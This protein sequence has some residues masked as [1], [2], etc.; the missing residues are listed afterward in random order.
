MYRKLIQ[1][2]PS[3]NRDSAGTALVSY[4]KRNVWHGRP[5][6]VPVELEIAFVQVLLGNN[7]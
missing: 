5:I 1:L 7:S 6:A 2:R 3:N 4:T